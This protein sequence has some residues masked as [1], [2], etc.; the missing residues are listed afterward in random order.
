MFMK[1]IALLKYDFMVKRQDP[2]SIHPIQKTLLVY[3]LGEYTLSY[4][5][6]QLFHWQEK[7]GKM[8]TNLDTYNDNIIM[9]FILRGLLLPKIIV[10]EF[11]G[12][13]TDVGMLGS[14]IYF[15]SD[16]L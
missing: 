3:C 13:R 7:S 5:G 8:H 2:F 14:G 6:K 12:T 15:A 16:P 11:G 9:I 10:E 4:C 1:S